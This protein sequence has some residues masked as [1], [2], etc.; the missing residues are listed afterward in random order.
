MEVTATKINVKLI[1]GIPF[2]K[3]YI[4]EQNVNV[5]CFNRNVI[6]ERGARVFRKILFLWKQGNKL[7]GCVTLQEKSRSR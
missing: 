7:N 5:I 2:Q 3:C 1:P 4:K 6:Y